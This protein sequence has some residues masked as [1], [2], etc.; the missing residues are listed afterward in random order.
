MFG[1]S[2]AEIEALKAKA[3]AAAELESELQV[4]SLSNL[5][6]N[7]HCPSSNH[8]S[9]HS[10]SL[11]PLHRWTYLFCD[12]SRV[13][14]LEQ[15]LEAMR[16]SLTRSTAD[17]SQIDMLTRENEENKK[18]LE[19]SSVHWF[20]DTA[21]SDTY[22][23]QNVHT[24]ARTLHTITACVYLITPSDFTSCQQNSH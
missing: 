15:Q 23:R 10:T 16:N 6:S 7:P 2:G 24:R 8:V 17:T 9:C 14:G 4:G 1:D 13:A 12:Q 18:L 22:T 19:V 21:S 11:H 3:L 5:L 20:C